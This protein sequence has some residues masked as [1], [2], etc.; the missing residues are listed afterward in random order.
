MIQLRLRREYKI[1]VEQSEHS[2]EE[3]C[4]LVDVTA[5][6]VGGEKCITVLIRLVYCDRAIILAVISHVCP[7]I[8]NLG[9]EPCIIDGCGEMARIVQQRVACAVEK[10]RCLQYVGGAHGCFGGVGGVLQPETEIVFLI[11]HPIDRQMGEWIPVIIFLAVGAL[12]FSAYAGI[13]VDLELI[14]GE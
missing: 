4:Q 9:G 12:E 11:R 8:E 10:F 13:G 3:D 14:D 6:A 7:H 5:V 2:V 1:A